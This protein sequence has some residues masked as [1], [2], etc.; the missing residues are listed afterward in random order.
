MPV[1]HKTV[2]HKTVATCRLAR[3]GALAL[4]CFAAPAAAQ[5]ASSPAAPPVPSPAERS[6]EIPV[7]P[8]PNNVTPSQA[9]GGPV[10][11][12]AE[13]IDPLVRDLEP[14]PDPEA[15]GAPREPRLPNASPEEP[16]MRPLVPPFGP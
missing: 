14:L 15:P 6:Q 9:I 16:A 5:T 2:V 7:A 10:P 3:A 12:R 11:G 1:V 13:A 8:L 4:L